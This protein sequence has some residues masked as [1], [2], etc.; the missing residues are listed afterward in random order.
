MTREKAIK[1]LE[2]EK[3]EHITTCKGVFYETRTEAVDA[4]I[5]AL[6]LLGHLKDRPCAVCEFRK[7]NGCCKWSCVFEEV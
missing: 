4:G 3:T 6:Q 5:R 2:D 1:Y 7:E